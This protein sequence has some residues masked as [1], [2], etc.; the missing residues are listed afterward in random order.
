MKQTESSAAYSGRSLVVI[1]AQQQRREA[2]TVAQ[3]RANTYDERLLI[4]TK[5]LRARLSSALVSA[6]ATRTGLYQ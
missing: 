1:L 5:R 3:K 6:L 4:A 2:L